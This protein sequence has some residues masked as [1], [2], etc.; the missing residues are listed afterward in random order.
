MKIYK[1]VLSVL[2]SFSLILGQQVFAQTLPDLYIS[3]ISLDK[4]SYTPNSTINGTFSL[5]NQG[6]NDAKDIYLLI[7]LVGLDEGGHVARV[8]YDTKK[9]GPIEIG[10]NTTQTIPFTYTLKTIPND[11][12]LGIHIRAINKD[13][14]PIHWEVIKLKATGAISTLQPVGAYVSSNEK[15]YALQQGPTVKAGDLVTFNAIYLNSSKDTYTVIPT[16]TLVDKSQSE[17][18]DIFPAIES[19][20]KIVPNGTT[21]ISFS[22]PTKDLKSGVYLSKITL[23]DTSGRNRAPDLYARYIIDG[24]VVDIQSVYINKPL[25]VNAN[26]QA[27]ISVG[28]TGRPINISQFENAT[29]TTKI[30][31]TPVNATIVVKLFNEKE[32]KVA[33][34]TLP[35]TFNLSG[36]INIPLTI[37]G[38][39]KI[40]TADIS[41]LQGGNVISNYKGQ[42]IYDAD[43]I[44]EKGNIVSKNINTS[45]LL[46]LITGIALLVLFLILF[47]RKRYKI[48]GI[49]FFFIVIVGGLFFIGRPNSSNANTWVSDNA[50][51]LVINRAPGDTAGVFYIIQGGPPSTISI[52]EPYNINTTFYM[53]ACYNATTLANVIVRVKDAS[54][55]WQ[56]I[57]NSTSTLYT[58]NSTAFQYYVDFLAQNG[59]SVSAYNVYGDMYLGSYNAPSAPVNN[60]D[61]LTTFEDFWYVYGDPVNY[62]QHVGHEVGHWYMNVTAPICGTATSTPSSIAPSSNLCTSGTPTTPTAFGSTWSWSCQGTGNASTTCSSTRTCSGGQHVSDNT[63]ACD[64]GF[65]LVNGICTSN[66]SCSGTSTSTCPVSQDCNYV[67]T[68]VSG[69]CN[70]TTTPGICSGGGSC[71]PVSIGYNLNPQTV[72]SSSLMCNLT[73]N[74]TNVYSGGGACA[75]S[76]TCTLDGSAK[77][78]S[79]SQPISVGTH[80]LT[81]TDGATSFTVSPKCKTVGSFGEF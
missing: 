41:V 36:F 5:A 29:S 40:L 73:W 15:K 42:V 60:Y 38:E 3:K 22:L 48:A 55:Q 20:V 10:S 65:S 32:E 53:S 67:A 54:N 18:K 33:E 58:F 4:T 45:P 77:T 72:A 1:I 46:Y 26:S 23:T 78:A 66:T 24:D 31:D 81:C 19:S 6:G 44:T 35:S 2:F 80:N 47:I 59:Y 62:F 61:F 17:I 16:V 50:A 70:Y 56:I 21:S 8:I 57:N 34:V 27:I 39:S 7:S 9:Y 11:P 76:I 52:N 49:I 28:Y 30:S 43:K 79:S 12:S 37:S 14:A 75:N 71:V 64:S 74:A 51:D 63:C 68:C 69:S 25:P 13:G